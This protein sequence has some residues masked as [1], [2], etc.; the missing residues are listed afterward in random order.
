MAFFHTLGEDGLEEITD[1]RKASYSV[2]FEA[3]FPGSLAGKVKKIGGGAGLVFL[4]NIE[5]GEERTF[6]AG[7]C[8]YKFEGIPREIVEWGET[9]YEKQY[10]KIE[11]L[12]GEIFC[13]VRI[14]EGRCDYL[15]TV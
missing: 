10:L 9:R 11:I 1:G 7:F 12:P 2:V 3:S 6:K 14:K 5:M 13:Y 4:R 15:E 8:S